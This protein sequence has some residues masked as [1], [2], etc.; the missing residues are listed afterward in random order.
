MT[1]NSSPA[2]QRARRSDVERN[3]RTLLEAASRVFATEGID[4]PIRSIAAEA[5]V[6][7]AT[8]YRHFATRTHL[9][10]A[11][12]RYQIDDCVDTGRRL[13]DRGDAP[14]EALRDWVN[15]FVEFILTKHG[16]AE[17][18]G[19]G[20]PAFRGLHAEFLER[21]VPI[22]ADLLAAAEAA[23]EIS[24]GVD[25]YELMRAIGNLCIGDRTDPGYRARRMIDLLLSGLSRPEPPA[26]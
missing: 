2:R 19:S 8:M 4:A 5:G 7:I 13:L 6:G 12:Y 14:L 20:D 15:H 18:L 10:V 25:A 16:L 26:H 17:A 11:V 3:E 22:C 24:P 1:D 9:V 21:L 23:R